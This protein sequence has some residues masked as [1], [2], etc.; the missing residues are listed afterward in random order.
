MRTQNNSLTNTKSIALSGVISALCFVVMYLAAVTDI[1]DLSGMVLCSMI[2]IV[3]V[4]EIGKYYPWLIWL[5]AG[6]LCMVLLPKKDVAL[7]FVMFGGVYPMVKA[8]FEKFPAPVAWA[9]KIVFFNLVFTGWFLL[10]KFI[11]G[12]DAGLELGVVA[13]LAANA[14]FVLA[15]VAFSLMANLYVTKLRAKLGIGKRKH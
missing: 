12:L 9:M 10:T 5:V 1:I 13:Y 4:I 2:I 14:F 7:E 11:F 8:L 3:A 15:D 6:I